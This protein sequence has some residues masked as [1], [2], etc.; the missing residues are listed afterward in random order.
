M[1]NDRAEY[2]QALAPQGPS[3]SAPAQGLDTARRDDRL[4]KLYRAVEQSANGVV[5]TDLNGVIEYVNPAFTG[6]TGYTLG[7]IAGQ[8]PRILKSGETP[9]EEYARLWQTIAAGGEWRGVFHNRRKNGELY[10]ERAS[11]SP[12]R[13][14]NGAITHFL[15]IKEDI[16]EQK[17]IEDALRASE[18]KFRSIIEQLSD[19]LILV[20]W[21]GT[22]TEWNPGQERI[23]GYRREEIIGR[24]VWDVQALLNADEGHA[25]TMRE[26][27]QQ[28]LASLAAEGRAG[29]LDQVREHTIRC[30]DGS[31]RIIQSIAFLIEVDGAATIATILR[32]MTAWHDAQQALRSGDARFRAI[33]DS[34]N[35]AVFELDAEG[36]FIGIYGGRN[37]IRGDHLANLINHTVRESFGD[38]IGATCESAVAQALGGMNATFLLKLTGHRDR[39][40]H[41]T[42]SPVAYGP[43]DE[44]RTVVGVA[45]DV[46]ALK[47]AETSEH[48]ARVLAEALRDTAEALATQ[49]DPELLLGY[50]LEIVGRVVPHDAANLML[51][52]D[53]QARVAAHR[54]YPESFAVFFRSFRFSLSFTN[55]QHM[56][57]TRTPALVSDT[58]REASWLV[59]PETEWIRSYVGA[60]ITLRR[61]VIG[62]VSLDSGTPGF[63][64]PHHAEWLQA[65]CNQ[66]A[67]AL[68]NAR[69][70]DQVRR[71]KAELERRVEQRTLELFRA[72]EH[73][74]A[75]LNNSSDAIIVTRDGGLISQ[76]NPAFTEMFGYSVDDVFHRPLNVLARPADSTI[77]DAALHTVQATRQPARIEIVAQRLAGSAF[78]ADVVLAPIHSGFGTGI[79]CSVRDITQHRQLEQDLREALDR[80]RELNELKT[81]F[82]STVSHEFRTPLTVIATSASLIYQYADRLTA[83]QKA[84]HFEK[85]QSEVRELAALLEDVLVISRGEAGKL[86][87]E[88]TP[89]DLAQH[90]QDAVHDLELTTNGSRRFTY[91][92]VGACPLV[93]ADERLVRQI[94]LNL[95]SNA[96]KYSA[97]GSPVEVALHGGDD[98]VVLHVRDYGVGI[99]EADR[100]HVFEIFHRGQNAAQIEGTGLGLAIVQQ[101][102]TLLG[103]TL[104]FE[105]A[106]GEGTT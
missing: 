61:E 103:W 84:Q 68:E 77:V 93:Q 13:D 40:F 78:V 70:Y 86:R 35:D 10:W 14:E 81:R 31:R 4:R 30:A 53:G 101:A 104:S 57:T 71:E 39:Y 12:I 42:L 67:L 87:A 73:V 2:D 65:F 36:R 5:I 59:I 18:K 17:R 48:E 23:S 92:Q 51:V 102:A 7:E 90:V 94:V 32:D 95:L 75:I 64:K 49:R 34:I 66:A 8:N 56:L 99:P 58:T 9:P 91:T 74:E 1:V 98:Q 47:Q 62:F 96:V 69:L 27:T 72:K 15:A 38:E 106:L 46:T 41:V 3:D 44:P 43:H 45:R 29:W 54:G 20:D 37:V 76:A 100:P 89:L 80:E 52:E 24:K 88:L 105:S 6:L 50:I 26:H 82:I 60:P 55:F 85:I 11:I 79:V 25:Q 16:T 97:E 63:F 21:D 19:G 83:E 33:I 28:A 22:I